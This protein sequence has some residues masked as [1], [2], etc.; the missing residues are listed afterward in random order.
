MKSFREAAAIL[1][2]GFSI[3]VLFVVIGA[4]LGILP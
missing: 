4:L 2:G 1:W 3:V